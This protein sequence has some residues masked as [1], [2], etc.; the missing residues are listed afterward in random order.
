MSECN[1]GV[2]TI[3]DHDVFGLL[4][5]LDG[6]GFRFRVWQGEWE[7]LGHHAGA[8][9]RVKLPGRAEQAYL[10]AAAVDLADTGNT[11]LCFAEPV[12]APVM[13]P[14]RGGQDG[15]RAARLQGRR[16]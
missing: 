5:L 7:T 2:V 10:L 16:R 12:A 4:V 13:G 6:G 1:T 11:W 3:D 14:A 9:L 15:S 8:V